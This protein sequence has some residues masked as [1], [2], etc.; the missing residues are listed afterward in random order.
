MKVTP[1]NAD[2]VNRFADMAKEIGKSIA[3]LSNEITKHAATLNREDGDT[4]DLFYE[5]LDRSRQAARW[6]GRINDERTIL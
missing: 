4:M 1:E 5:L 3:E 2:S 6:M